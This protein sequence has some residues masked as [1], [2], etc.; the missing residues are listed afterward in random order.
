MNGNLFEQMFAGVEEGY[1]GVTCFRDKQPHTAF[2][3]TKSLDQ[4]CNF[5]LEQNQHGHNVYVSM[6]TFETIPT[7]GRGCASDPGYHSM[8]WVDLDYGIE[9]HKSASN[10]PTREAAMSLLE[11]FPL[12]PTLIT[13]TGH[14]L[15]AFWCFDHPIDAR[16][17]EGVALAGSVIKRVQA[18]LAHYSADR[19]WSMDNT[20]DLARI[21]RVPG[22]VNWKDPKNPV[23]GAVLE[24]NLDC[25][26]SV[27]ALLAACLP[28]TK[29]AKRPAIKELSATSTVKDR[30]AIS[31]G[32]IP[33]SSRNA[34]LT[35]IAGTMRRRGMSAQAIAA[36]LQAENEERCEEPLDD[37]EIER[38]AISVSRYEPTKTQADFVIEATGVLEQLLPQVSLE[39]S[40]AFS[41]DVVSA[42][43]VLSAFDQ[44]AF[45]RMKSRIKT[46]VKAKVSLRE[47]ELAVRAAAGKLR[48]EWQT[49]QGEEARPR[50]LFP[51][52]GYEIQL[53]VGYTMN[54]SGVSRSIR[55]VD[56]LIFPVPVALSRSFR[57]PHTGLEMVELIYKRGVQ[58]RRVAAERSVVFSRNRVMEL[59]DNGFPVTSE[60]AKDLVVFLSE[61][62]RINQVPVV[63]CA[64]SLGWVGEHIL[65]WDGDSVY[66]DSRGFED[67][68]A[69][70]DMRGDIASWVKLTKPVR[71]SLTGRL[72][73]AAAYASP[74]VSLVGTRTSGVMLWGGSQAGK[75]AAL[76]AAVSIFGHPDKLMVNMYATRVSL[77]QQA[78]FLRHLPLFIDE[79]QL[80]G[81]DQALEQLV[82]MI[83]GGAGK[84][85]GK[86]SRGLQARGLWENTA[87][88]TGEFPISSESS[89]AGVRGRL[90]EINVTKVVENDDATRLHRELPGQFGLAGATFI[91]AVKTKREEIRGRYDEWLNRTTN[92]FPQLS[93]SHAAMLALL[94][95]A[96]ELAAVCVHEQPNE[97]AAEDAWQF[98]KEISKL[99][100]TSSDLDDAVRAKDWVISK[101]LENAHRFEAEEGRPGYEFGAMLPGVLQIAPTVLIRFLK[102]GGFN[103]ARAKAD[104]VQRGWLKQFKDANGDLK[105]KWFDECGGRGTYKRGYW[106][107][108]AFPEW[109]QSPEE[110]DISGIRPAIPPG[111]IN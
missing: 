93:G 11:Q 88:I 66:L 25:R 92:E 43:A 84:G 99:V 56:T 47:L 86:K 9:G 35:S 26:Y 91:Q 31:D 24:L 33:V 10:P 87:L 76:K 20:A 13:F 39:P 40:H 34:T 36:A 5:A 41:Q 54:D 32:K 57:N 8:A 109:A 48:S 50:P 100:V 69:A 74:L 62:E 78:T 97:A 53:P 16:T 14:G 63:P 42:L 107:Y 4:A 83:S 21:M 22:T 7:K 15:Q 89:A 6:K 103:A 111:A 12:R 90:L 19:G 110:Q 29:P 98:I 81:N 49:Q 82:Y 72:M 45:S 75:T 18:T 67:I 77:E 95:L 106:C 55:G 108:L 65:P 30:A 28:E 79:R 3:D 104:F 2:F 68:S 46:A 59:A 17:P 71:D 80:A 27:D 101:Y 94:V 23:Q 37:D 96:D 51:E 61:L 70:M 1:V 58:I 52:L 105:I 38:I 102:E 44:L 64:A 60:N 73:L 85:R